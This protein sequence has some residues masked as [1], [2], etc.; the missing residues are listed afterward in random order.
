MTVTYVDTAYLKILGDRIGMVNR[1]GY[2]DAALRDMCS[3]VLARLGWRG[4]RATIGQ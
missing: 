1:D 3:Q 4:I 2:D